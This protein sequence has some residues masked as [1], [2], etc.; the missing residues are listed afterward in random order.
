MSE[1]LQTV[2]PSISGNRCFSGLAIQNSPDSA[3]LIPD[4][5]SC[6]IASCD[7]G[8]REPGSRVHR[9][10]A[11]IRRGRII[12]DGQ[13]NTTVQRR[14]FPGLESLALVWWQ[15]KWGRS[16]DQR[17]ILDFHVPW[18][19]SAFISVDFIHSGTQSGYR[20]FRASLGMLDA[21]AKARKSYAIVAHVTNPMITD[22]LL[23][24]FGWEQHCLEWKGRH[25]IKRF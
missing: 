2:E 9:P 20:N 24:R 21:I 18:G 5:Q 1:F 13:G 23:K 16:D 4:A 8:P 3:N 25:W 19:M 15:S 10:L 17:C 7:T 12:V 22:R 11:K 14:W 6:G